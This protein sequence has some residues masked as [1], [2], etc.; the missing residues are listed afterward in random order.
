[1]TQTKIMLKETK[2]ITAVYFWN[3]NNNADDDDVAE[4]LC[5]R[6]LASKKTNKQF[7]MQ[8]IRISVWHNFNNEKSLSKISYLLLLIL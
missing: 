3:N 6:H 7:L 2:S 4:L 1:M 8:K 5:S